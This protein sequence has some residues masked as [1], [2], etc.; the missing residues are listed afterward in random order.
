ML[1]NLWGRYGMRQNKTQTKFVHR[2]TD[3][4]RLHD[5]PS[6][7]ITGV[8]IITEDVVQ[9]AYRKAGEEFVATSLDTNIYIAVATTAWAR[10]R[11]YEDLDR[12]QERVVYCDTVSIVYMASETPAEN[13]VTGCFLGQMGNELED[14]DY[15]EDFVSGGPKNYGYRTRKGKTCV[16]VKGF[17][18]NSTNAPVLSFENIKQMVLGALRFAPTEEADIDYEEEDDSTVLN[19]LM[20][21]Y[22]KRPGEPKA[23]MERN[24]RLRLELLEQHEADPNA[25]AS[26]IVADTGVGISAYNKVRIFR[27]RDLRIIQKPEQK[28]YSFWFDKRIMCDTFDTVPFGFCRY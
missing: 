12:L 23:R 24:K 5:D 26:A 19:H 8:R 3:L 10:M 27:T 7:E 16:K 11:L 15:I 17:T 25:R 1:N 9:V 14:D 22:R 6:I 13:L 2:F 20:E 18:L 28:L 4:Q 21:G